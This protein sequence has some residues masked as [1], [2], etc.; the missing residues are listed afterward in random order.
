VLLSGFLFVKQARA[1]PRFFLL[2]FFGEQA[3]AK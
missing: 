3:K 1:F 2:P